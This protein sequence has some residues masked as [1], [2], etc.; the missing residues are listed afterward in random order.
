MADVIL[1]NT[2]VNIKGIFN[3]PCTLMVFL[4]Q[5]PY[6]LQDENALLSLLGCHQTMISQNRIK[7]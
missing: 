7:T 2:Q 3:I 4:C 1:K 5:C 6:S